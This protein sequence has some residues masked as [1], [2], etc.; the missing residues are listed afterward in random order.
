MLQVSYLKDHK[1]IVLVGLKKR[2]FKSLDLVDH[3]IEED[4]KRKNVQTNL[5]EN[6]SEMNKISKEIGVL[7]KEG[8][9]EEAEKAK[10]KTADFKE[11]I[12]IYQQELKETEQNL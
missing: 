5:D 8:K 2:N 12:Q 7:M 1:E 11:K 9:K 4:Q 10:V 6:L 3:A